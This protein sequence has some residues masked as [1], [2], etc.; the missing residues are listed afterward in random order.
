MEAPQERPRSRGE[1]RDQGLGDAI[2]CPFVSCKYH[3]ALDVTSSGTLVY[4]TA[5]VQPQEDGVPE[6]DV[7]AMEE[8]CALRVAE[9]GEQT[10][11]AISAYFG[12]VSECVRQVE[13]K[14][15]ERLRDELEK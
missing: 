4:T 8:T 10:L 6:I 12:V 3:L 11:E 2:A 5:W 7:N 13:Q 15:L 9:K 1:C 14:G